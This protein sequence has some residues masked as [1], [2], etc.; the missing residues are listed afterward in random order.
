MELDDTYENIDRSRGDRKNQEKVESE[1]GVRSADPV[2]GKCPPLVISI[3]L[4]LSIL[5]S[6]V[7][8]GT[9]IILFTQITGEMKMSETNLKMELSQLKSNFTQIIGE[10]KRSETDLK[11][12]ELLHIRCP[13]EWRL[14]QK[15]CYYFS[16][17]KKNW[18]DAQKSCASMDANLVVINK[19][20]EQTF[21]KGWQNDK[22][23]WI[24]LSDLISEGDWRWVD[25]TDYTSSVKFWD[26]S[27]PNGGEEH[28]VTMFTEG[29]WHDWP[30][31]FGHLSICEK[32]AQFWFL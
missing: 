1:Q 19:A 23:H 4:G 25:G 13:D 15:N 24:G 14:F 30:C 2:R 28:C 32:S 3:L 31:N 18:T 29:K 16:S 6:V 21:V 10:M 5:L 11:S 17:Y 22:D 9:A 8:L 27:Q 7:I 12:N 20:E 26:I